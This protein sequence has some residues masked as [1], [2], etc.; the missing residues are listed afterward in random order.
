[1]AIIHIFKEKVG[2]MLEKGIIWIERD[3]FDIYLAERICEDDRSSLIKIVDYCFNYKPSV[4]PLFINCKDGNYSC[5]GYLAIFDNKALFKK[6]SKSFKN[7]EQ[8]IY[9][10]ALFIDDVNN[11]DD[12]EIISVMRRR[13]TRMG[14]WREDYSILVFH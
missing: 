8:S 12:E 6:F 3:N 10:G 4:V 13:A 11:L 5:A 7:I 1:M 9:L 14:F 2:F